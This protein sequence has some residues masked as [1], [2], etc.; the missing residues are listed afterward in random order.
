LD[1]NKNSSGQRWKCGYCE[2]FLSH[3]DLEYCSLT[4][5]ASERF[6]NK[7]TPLQ[8]MVEFREDGSM[9]LCRAVRSHQER[10]RARKQ[11]AEAANPQG[12]GGGDDNEIVE[13]LDSD[14]D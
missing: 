5:Q 2:N 12:E 11:A 7:I 10:T 13:L 6:G 8:H 14:S 1:L 9:A 3:E 4:K